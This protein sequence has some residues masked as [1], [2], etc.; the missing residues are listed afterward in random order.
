MLRGSKLGDLQEKIINHFFVCETKHVESV[1]HI[2]TSIGAQRPSVSRSIGYLV[3]Q[4]YLVEDTEF[5]REKG[6]KFFEKSIF[7]TDKGAA[8]AVVVLGVKLDQVINYNTKYDNGSKHE[9]NRYKEI[10]T[11]PEKREYIFRKSMEFVLTSSLF[12]SAGHI[13]S[14]LTEEESQKMKLSEFVAS[15]EYFESVGLSKQGIHNL[16]DFLDKYKID[17]KSMEKY[18]LDRKQEID[19]ALKQIDDSDTSSNSH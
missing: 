13:R 8:Y 4:K 3:E 18:L 7:V 9:W 5:R 14:Q 15:R 12:D 11:I 10:F 17:K 19:S 1:I 2:S 6:G 16:N